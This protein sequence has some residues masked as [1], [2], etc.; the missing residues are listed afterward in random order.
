MTDEEKKKK[1]REQS[2]IEEFLYNVMKEVTSQ[3]MNYF[4]DEWL[5]WH[6]V[7][8]NDRSIDWDEIEEWEW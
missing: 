7:D 4:F 3:M 5:A 1:K 8:L 2:W 6:Y